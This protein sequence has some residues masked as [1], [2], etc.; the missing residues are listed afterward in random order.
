MGKI[1][2]IERGAWDGA[3]RVAEGAACANGQ[4]TLA[5]TVEHN[6]EE[7]RIVMSEFNARRVFG[8]LSMMLELPLS[9]TVGKA[10]KI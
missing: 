3:V 1:P 6:G 4:R 9:S 10:I 5:V 7:Q 2:P 8:M